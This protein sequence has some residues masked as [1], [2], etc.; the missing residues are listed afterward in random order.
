MRL[1][2]NRVAACVDELTSN[3][4]A[5]VGERARVCLYT[6]E[7]QPRKIWSFSEEPLSLFVMTVELL[8]IGVSPNNSA[9]RG[10]Q[11]LVSPWVWDG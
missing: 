9:R 10:V 6:R 11:H 4:L 3:F 5:S 1:E 7:V 8:A 2:V